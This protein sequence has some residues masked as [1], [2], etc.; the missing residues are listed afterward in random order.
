MKTLII[1]C[2]LNILFLVASAQKIINAKK[3]R[4]YVGQEVIVTG[5]LISFGNSSY[6]QA[7]NFVLGADSNHKQLTVILQGIYYQKG[8]NEKFS[9][10]CWIG[11]YI[12][13]VVEIKGII[14]RDGKIV[15]MDATDQL[16]LK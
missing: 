16:V 8:E 7:A 14:R 10:E 2:F 5:K 6:L 3:A 1:I 12:N 4:K 15:W 13:K 11:N 9:Q